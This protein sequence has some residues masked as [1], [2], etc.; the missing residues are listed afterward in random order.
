MTKKRTIPYL[1]LGFA[2]GIL[3]M[4]LVQQFVL[5]PSLETTL[6]NTSNEFNL[7]CPVMI[8]KITR[9]DNTSVV[10][11]KEFRFSYTIVNA[12]KDSVDKKELYSYLEPIVLHGIKANPALE[13]LRTKKITITCVYKDKHE[14]TLAEIRVTPDKYLK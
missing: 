8:D 2:I 14:V 1:L 12:L 7:H 3:A 9:F 4:Y 5:Q 11:D 13:Y 6:L 10:N